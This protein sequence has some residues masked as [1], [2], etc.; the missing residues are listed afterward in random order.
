ME[1]FFSVSSLILYGTIQIF[2]A[3]L[4][5]HY[6]SSRRQSL[7]TDVFFCTKLQKGG[8]LQLWRKI[9]SN[10]VMTSCPRFIFDYK[11]QWPLNGLN[12]GPLTYDVVTNIV[13]GI[14]HKF[15]KLWGEHNI[16]QG[17]LRNSKQF[18]HFLDLEITND[19]KMSWKMRTQSIY[20]IQKCWIFLGNFLNFTWVTSILILPMVLRSD[21]SN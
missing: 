17:F 4:N 2:T 7:E 21:F 12:Y 19:S 9:I 13:V 5:I 14:Y 20:W 15:P 3:L 16:T 10:S 18:K 1:Y 6:K 8:N 11:F